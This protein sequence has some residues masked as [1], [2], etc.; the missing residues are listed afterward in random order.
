MCTKHCHGFIA[1]F[2]ETRLSHVVSLR[3]AVCKKYERSLESPK[4]FSKVW[5]TGSANQKVS[6][7]LDHA[8][9]D[10]HKASMARL[11]ADS[12]RARGGTAVLAGF[13]DW[14]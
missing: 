8:T 12:V 1:N 9:S 5:I 7:V 14:P 13:G 6:I 10:V 4:N 3:C 2:S 11:Q